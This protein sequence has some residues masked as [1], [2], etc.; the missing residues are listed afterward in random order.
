MRDIIFRGKRIDTASQVWVTGSLL[1]WD[2]GTCEICTEVTSTDMNKVTVD[3]ETIGQFTGLLDKN[4]VK[5]FEGDKLESK[6][7]I[8]R[9]TEKDDEKF[10]VVEWDNHYD[11][12]FIGNMRTTCYNIS[13]GRFCHYAVIGNIHDNPELTEPT[14]ESE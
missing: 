8:D 13:A 9:C 2:D 14:K 12:C 11:A 7:I 1:K 6:E 5:I 4:G 3:R 10:A